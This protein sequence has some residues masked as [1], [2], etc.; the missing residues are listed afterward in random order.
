MPE[1]ILVTGGAGFVGSH[2]VD[3]LVARGHHVRV[4]D[5]LVP[6]VHGAAG[7]LPEYLNPAAEFIR[8]D[9]LDTA[10]LRTALDGVGVVYHQAA[11]VGV[12]QSMYEVV[13]Y[14]QLNTLGT[15]NLLQILVDAHQARHLRVRKLIVASSM[16][17]YGEGAYHCAG[18]GTV[19]PQLR[20]TDQLS[21]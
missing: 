20:P 8:G 1:T 13:K 17:I 18:D 6:Q 12:G 2:L 10:T 9:L 3:A 21:R 11:A 4:Y 14:V 16:S 15:A 5:T 7:S 19:F